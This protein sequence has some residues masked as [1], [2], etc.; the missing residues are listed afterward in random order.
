MTRFK[1]YTS[2][3]FFLFTINLFCQNCITKNDTVYCD[4]PLDSKNY[5]FL[6][7]I[8]SSFTDKYNFEKNLQDKYKVTSI[9]SSTNE[10]EIRYVIE[11]FE[12]ESSMIS[13]IYNQG[14]WKYNYQFA[15]YSKEKEYIIKKCKKDTNQLNFINNFYN[16]K[17]QKRL[18]YE[19]AKKTFNLD[20]L[21]RILA[22]NNI[23]DQS[24]VMTKDDKMYSAY[25]KI[26][27]RIEHFNDGLS[28][29]D[30]KSCIV[31][32][33]ILDLTG[34]Y[35]FSNVDSYYNMYPNNKKLNEQIEIFKIFEFI[36]NQ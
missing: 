13:L 33:K 21:F 17:D 32:F 27:N 3:L 24:N 36:S 35:D 4:D 28:I 23:F 25:N 18:K 31:F 2:G 34:N 30:G 8:N 15:D 7:K 14:H 6:G 10:I 5:I 1:L 16:Q 11:F 26:T 12:E 19:K 20:S 22:I 29:T 9:G